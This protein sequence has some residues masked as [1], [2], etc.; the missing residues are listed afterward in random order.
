MVTA[1]TVV[2]VVA[3]VVVVIVAVTVLVVAATAVTVGLVVLAVIVTDRLRRDLVEELL[4]LLLLVRELGSCKFEFKHSNPGSGGW[5]S[6]S[7][8]LPLGSAPAS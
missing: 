4:L 5:G 8:R 2:T 1:V 6:Y 3:V 7:R